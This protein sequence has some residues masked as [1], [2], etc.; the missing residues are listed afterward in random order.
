LD[1]Y[2]AS[3]LSSVSSLYFDR[4]RSIDSYRKYLAKI[5]SCSRRD[6]DV[7]GESAILRDYLW[8]RYS[9]KALIQSIKQ[10]PDQYPILRE[11]LNFHGSYVDLR[12]LDVTLEWN[13][14]KLFEYLLSDNN[15]NYHLLL[16][17]RWLLEN[18]CV[19]QII[20][21]ATLHSINH[22]MIYVNQIFENLHQHSLHAN[23]EDVHRAKL[24]LV[25]HRHADDDFVPMI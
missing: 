24:L 23:E 15:F 13:N 6:V 9:Y 4:H 11:Y 21:N 10:D 8:E 20:L 25:E 1:V 14:S 12:L 19:F 18:P 16:S 17:Q 2:L 7:G 3:N 5:R 22:P